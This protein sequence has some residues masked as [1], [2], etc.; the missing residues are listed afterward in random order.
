M[1]YKITALCGLQEGFGVNMTSVYKLQQSLLFLQ[2]K[3]HLY[4][5]QMFSLDNNYEFNVSYFIDQ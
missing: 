5:I 3:F 4:F 2:N 1:W